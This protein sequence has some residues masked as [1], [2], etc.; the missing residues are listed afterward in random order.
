MVMKELDFLVKSIMKS[1]KSYTLWFHR[2]W[3]IERG[4]VIER[5]LIP[6]ADGKP[7]QQEWRSRILETEMKLCD[8]MLMMDERNFHCWNYRL[9]TAL[10][11]LKEIALRTSEAI[12][13]DAQVGFLETECEMAEKLIRKNFSNYSAWHYRSKLLPELYQ[14]LPNEGP[15]AIP[16]PKIQEDLALLK[17]AFFTDPKD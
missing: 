4:L 17:H 8:K 13:K 11:Y 9:L 14:R 5:E 15:Y 12:T 16:F 7:D 1:P 10:L 2:Q 6:K 3:I